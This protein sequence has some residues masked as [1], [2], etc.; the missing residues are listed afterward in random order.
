[1][2]QTL[3]DLHVNDGQLDPGSIGLLRATYPRETPL[4]DM[5]DRL[6]RD[7]YLLLKGL[8]P[9][10]DV[11][12]ARQKYFEMLAPTG[13]LK[14]GTRTVDGIFD[15]SRDATDFPGF[16]TGRKGSGT[17]QSEQ[18]TDLALK[19]HAEDWY[20]ND[21]CK[22]PVMMEF[23]KKF[24][25]WKENTFGLER[26]LLRNNLP[27]NKAIGVHYDYIFLRHG[28]DSVLTAW[29]PIGNV[30]IRG[31]GLIYLEHGL[32]LVLIESAKGAC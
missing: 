2:P 27:G 13:I 18:F 28:E 10:E 20:K 29:V 24:T 3:P 17:A 21:L 14:P 19:A 11:L 9:R 31:G 32:F 12:K 1:M 25:G 6:A 23:I 30:G 26:T 8:L 15:S 22:H 4:N 16:G 5:R 7:G